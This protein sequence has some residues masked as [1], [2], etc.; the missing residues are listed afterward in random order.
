MLPD[1]TGYDIYFFNTIVP[2]DNFY[3]CVLLLGIFPEL[4]LRVPTSIK[5][6]VVTSNGS[7]IEIAHLR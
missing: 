1:C 4:L 2:A 5:N 3:M 7:H 6:N